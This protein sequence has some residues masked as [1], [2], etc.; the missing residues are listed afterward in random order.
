MP[1]PQAVAARAG[2]SILLPFGI[3]WS[4]AF[5]LMIMVL[6][7]ASF[8]AFGIYKETHSMKEAIKPLFTELGGRLIS[9]DGEI[10]REV[11]KLET[12]KS[13]FVSNSAWDTMKHFLS[14]GWSVINIISLVYFIFVNFFIIYKLLELTLPHCS[15]VFY[16]MWAI[17]IIGLIENAWTAYFLHVFSFPLAGVFSLILYLTHLGNPIYQGLYNTFANQSIP[18]VT[19]MPPSTPVI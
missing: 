10:L 12:D 18:L 9:A 8:S 1:T 13:P 6:I 5:W 2:F 4:V 17:I 14:I 7:H 19:D 16:A 15:S 11:T 3:F